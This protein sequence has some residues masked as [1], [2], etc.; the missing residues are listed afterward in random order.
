MRSEFSFRE[1]THRLNLLSESFVTD[2]SFIIIVWNTEFN[3]L[4]FMFLLIGSVGALLVSG[5]TLSLVF[6]LS[7]CGSC[8]GCGDCGVGY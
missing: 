1:A 7:D 5:I 4:N 3:N 2:S 6:F 8:G